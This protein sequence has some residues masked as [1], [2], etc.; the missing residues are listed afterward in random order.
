MPIPAPG[1]TGLAAAAVVLASAAIAVASATITA[2]SSAPLGSS[3]TV[4]AKG[5]KPGRY[6]VRLYAIH[7][8]NKNWACLAELGARAAKKVTSISVT[9]KL[10]SKLHCWSGS[11]GTSHGTIRIKPGSYQLVVAVPNGPAT[12]APGSSVAQKTLTLG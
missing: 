4:S 11:P 8:P 6:A 3:I 2:P 7:A 12:T 10:P 5:L 9:A 1:R